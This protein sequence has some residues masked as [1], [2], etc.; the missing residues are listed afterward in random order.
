MIDGE[1]K[2]FQTQVINSAASQKNKIKWMVIAPK[3]AE[4]EG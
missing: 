4:I 2:K 3:L 1:V